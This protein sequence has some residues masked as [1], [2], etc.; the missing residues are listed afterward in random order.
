M[1]GEPDFLEQMSSAVQEREQKSQVVDRILRWIPAADTKLGGMSIG[2][3][4]FA[5]R[6]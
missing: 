1:C 4:I 6:R 5:R 3:L 2:A